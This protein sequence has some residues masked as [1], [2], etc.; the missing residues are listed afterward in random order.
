MAK[1]LQIA[2]FKQ[3]VRE[4]DLQEEL[5]GDQ[6]DKPM[7]GQDEK[8]FGKDKG[9]EKLDPFFVEATG[10]GDEDENDQHHA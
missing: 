8:V 5:G 10:S 9:V 7:V 4:K 6:G 3:Q 1:V 2:N